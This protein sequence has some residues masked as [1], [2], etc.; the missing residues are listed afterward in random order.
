MLQ[1]TI[2]GK[3]AELGVAGDLDAISLALYNLSIQDNFLPT[4]VGHIKV[5]KDAVSLDVSTELVV[6]RLVLNITNMKD[7]VVLD[8]QPIVVRFIKY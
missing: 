5:T 7:T 1:E 4:T 6:G 2:K 3:L 8:G